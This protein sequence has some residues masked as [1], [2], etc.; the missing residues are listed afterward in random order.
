[1]SY[2]AVGN[3]PSRKVMERIGLVRDLAGDFDHPK[4][5]AG[6]PLRRQLRFPPLNS[7][8]DSTADSAGYPSVP[9]PWVIFTGERR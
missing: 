5:P 2:T 1:M 4:L 7:P 9:S 6:H 3:L 8:D